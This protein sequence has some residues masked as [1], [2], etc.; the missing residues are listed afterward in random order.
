MLGS[1][2][3]FTHIKICLSFT[4]AIP[5]ALNAPIF[6]MAKVL[7]GESIYQALRKLFFIVSLQLIDNQ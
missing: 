7:E 6:G 5:P 3:K 4:D 2:M 1:E